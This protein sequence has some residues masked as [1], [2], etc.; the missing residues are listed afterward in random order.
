MT[1]K[2]ILFDMDET[3]LPMN[4]EKFVEEYF[5]TISLAISPLGYE[6][7]KLVDS[8]IKGTYAMVNGDGTRPNE[9]IFWEVFCG[10]YGK[11]ALEDK[12]H[13]DK[14]YEENFDVLKKYTSCNPKAA[15]TVYKLKSM[16]Y[17]L[18]LATNPLFPPLAIQKRISWAGLSH[19]DFEIYTTYENSSYC[20]PNPKYYTEIVEKLGLKPEECLM[21]GNDADDDLAAQ[22]AGL[23]VFLHTDCL[24]NRH[25]KD[26]S[27]YPQGSFDELMEFI[28]KR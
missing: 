15:Q 22:K 27:S 13:F 8:V 10:I 1:L 7:K 24:I 3:L 14:Y 4:Q 25:N 17:R 21:V 23:N 11:K 6:P 20:K 28:L 16:G 18:V 5:K 26:I 2:A 19:T 9:A 12:P